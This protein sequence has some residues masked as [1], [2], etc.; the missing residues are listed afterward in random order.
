MSTAT[1]LGS[2]PSNPATIEREIGGLHFTLGAEG[3]HIT[4]L[5]E[6]PIAFDVTAALA[7]SDFLR[8]PGARTLVSRAWLSEQHAATVTS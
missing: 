4:G 1:V 6:G 3:L 7:L 2:S 5:A 8:S